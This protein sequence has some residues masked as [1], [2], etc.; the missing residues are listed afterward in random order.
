MFWSYWFFLCFFV[1]MGRH[2]S[3]KNIVDN[4][5]KDCFHLRLYSELAHWHGRNQIRSTYCNQYHVYLVC[6][7]FEIKMFRPLDV[8]NSM[9]KNLLVFFTL[10]FCA[11]YSKL[12][13]T[14][15]LLLIFKGWNGIHAVISTVPYTELYVICHWWDMRFE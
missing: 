3:T 13:P 12:F 6:S 9:S 1:T 10:C 4:S 8:G 15:T 5:I 11:F 14:V 7:S 2:H